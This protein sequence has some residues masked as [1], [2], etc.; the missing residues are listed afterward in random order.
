MNWEVFDSDPED[1]DNEFVRIRWC[2]RED[3]FKSHI[4]S[5]SKCAFGKDWGT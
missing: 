3:M 4:E 2:K 5:W 1:M